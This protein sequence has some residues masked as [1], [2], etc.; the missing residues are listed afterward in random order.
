MPRPLLD[1]DLWAVIAPLLPPPQRRRKRYPGRKPLVH[2]E[3]LT[4]ILFVLRSAEIA[5][6]HTGHGSGLG[7]TRWVVE[8]TI[9]WLHQFR[10]LRIG[11]ERR[12]EIHEAFLTLGCA[13][14]CWRFLQV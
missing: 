6:R 5:R 13:I 8:R 1:N 3:T 10:R 2:R 7:K 9:T 12:P 14:I 4:G 11:Y